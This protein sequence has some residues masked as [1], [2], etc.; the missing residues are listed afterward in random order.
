[1][2]HRNTVECTALNSI[3]VS[4]VHNWDTE[5]RNNRLELSIKKYILFDKYPVEF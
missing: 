1:M 3:S 5:Y 4:V 2:F